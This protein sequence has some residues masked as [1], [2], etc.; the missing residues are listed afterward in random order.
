MFRSGPNYDKLKSNLR[1]AMNRF[2][3]MEKK[4]TEQNL[5]ARKEISEYLKQNKGDRARVRVEHII[6]EDYVV[7][8]YEILEMYCDLL[9]ARFGLIQNMKEVDPS[10][11]EAI[12]SLIWCAPR[13][14]TEIDEIKHISDIF[15][16]KYG[17]E[18]VEEALERKNVNEKVWQRLSLG[19]PSKVL[20]EQYLIEIA[21]SYNVPFEPDANVMMAARSNMLSFI[22]FDANDGNEKRMPTISN[23]NSQNLIDMNDMKNNTLIP[24]TFNI[25]ASVNSKEQEAINS[26]KQQPANP[27]EKNDETEPS[28]NDIPTYNDVI[29]SAPND[30]FALPSVPT[31]DHLSHTSN[32]DDKPVDDFD[33]LTKRFE[34]LRR[35]NL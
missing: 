7:E 27:N 2:K 28:K 3:L 33:D 25:N 19:P 22:N 6:R 29:A 30:D 4:K 34:A 9:L 12:S 1:L 20:V 26:A 14:F 18:Y 31:N 24:P 5:K 17:K 13:I 15:T 23:P 35:N 11:E 10:I 32:S 16:K 8:A 21:K